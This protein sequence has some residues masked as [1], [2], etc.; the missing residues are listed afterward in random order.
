MIYSRN[1]LENGSHIYY[2]KYI[3]TYFLF[4][5]CS[6]NRLL[7]YTLKSEI[8]IQNTHNINFDW[9]TINVPFS[10]IVLQLCEWDLVIRTPL[11]LGKYVLISYN[12]YYTVDER[13][14]FLEMALIFGM[15]L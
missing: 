6:Y 14:V 2:T 7:L 10:V 9:S 13:T 12:R 4:P 8:L 5:R 15:F 11:G 1:L 3:R